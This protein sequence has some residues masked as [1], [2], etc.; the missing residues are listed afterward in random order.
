MEEENK[1][2][3]MTSKELELLLCE[4]AGESW[5]AIEM[6]DSILNGNAANQILTEFASLKGQIDD[7]QWALE[8]E[9]YGEDL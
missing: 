7:L 3:M 9:R 4:F 2:G 8:E 5:V 6:K 1:G